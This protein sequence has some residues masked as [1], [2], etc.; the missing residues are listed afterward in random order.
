MISRMPA[1]HYDSL[2]AKV[3]A[4]AP[5]R[6][7]AIETL[8]RALRAT[9]IDGVATTLPLHLAVL[10]SPEFRSGGYDTRAIPGWNAKLALR[11][12]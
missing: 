10:E 3:I 11:K 6:E 12:P 4:H 8:L 9:V 2:L 7:A 1:P 5:T